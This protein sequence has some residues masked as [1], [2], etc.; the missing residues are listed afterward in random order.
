[1]SE[2]G[3]RVRLIDV[4]ERAKV[5][6]G[7]V[8][9]V[10]LGTGAGRVRVSAEKTELIKRLAEEMGFAPDNSARM[11]KGK[12]SKIIG[13][14]I[15]SY[16]SQ[17]AF[18]A[19]SVAEEILCQHGYR[20]MVGQTHDNYE[21]LKQYISDFTS[22]RVDGIICL[23]HGYSEFDTVNDLKNFHNVVYFGE[24]RKPG[25]RYV[26]YDVKAGMKMIIDH[27]VASGRKRIGHLLF[28]SGSMYMTR[29]IEGYK[30][31]LKQYDI[32]YD[33]KLLYKADQAPDEAGYM[34]IIDYLVEQQE[35]DSIVVHNDLWAVRLIKYLKKRGFDIPAQVAVAGCDNLEIGEISS[36]ELTTVDPKIKEQGRVVAEMIL[37]MIEGGKKIENRQIKIEPELIIRESTK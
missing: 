28:N 2:S 22:R 32:P 13:V 11:L 34:D 17:T 26:H 6:R 23:A 4:A 31:S 27:L 5:S 37:E 25:L 29:R 9:R 30:E 8:A 35:V 33:E 12:K 19:F 18:M 1:M 10:L 15:D 36:P 16:A 20:I 21:I 3:T 24:P 14:L 7:A